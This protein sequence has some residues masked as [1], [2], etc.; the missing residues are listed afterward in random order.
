MAEMQDDMRQELMWDQLALPS[1]DL[2]TDKRL[3]RGG[4]ITS[5]GRTAPLPGPISA[6]GVTIGHPFRRTQRGNTGRSFSESGPA[7]RRRCT[8]LVGDRAPAGVLLA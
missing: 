3:Q 2:I 7:A 1:A 6:L 4:D 5:I 8:S